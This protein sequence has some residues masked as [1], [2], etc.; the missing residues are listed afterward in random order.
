MDTESSTARPASQPGKFWVSRLR[1]EGLT[2]WNR[3]GYRTRKDI[4]S[5]EPSEWSCLEWREGFNRPWSSM[6]RFPTSVYSVGKQ[7]KRSVQPTLYHYLHLPPGPSTVPQDSNEWMRPVVDMSYSRRGI[8]TVYFIT[9]T[10]H[11]IGSNGNEALKNKGNHRSRWLP[12]INLESKGWKPLLVARKKQTWWYHQWCTL[13]LLLLCN[14]VFLLL[15]RKMHQRID[16]TKQHP[17]QPL[18]ECSL[19]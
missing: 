19:K 9:K 18:L 3:Q 7:Y 15:V 10:V 1:K 17:I 11:K 5:R 8:Y 16:Y 2:F 13:T 12:L 14:L 6:A 4:A